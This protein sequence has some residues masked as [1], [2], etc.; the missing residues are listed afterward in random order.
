M[1]GP[2]EGIV[3]TML[4]AAASCVG[5][6]AQVFIKRSANYKQPCILRTLL[7][8]STGQLKTP[9]QAIALEPLSRLEKEA[10]VRFQQE[11]KAYRQAIAEYSSDLFQRTERFL[12]N[13]DS[14]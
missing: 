4:A 14:V 1:P 2:V 13:D 3:M 12:C 8:G 5:T 7:V 6:H 11:Q 10:V 9:L